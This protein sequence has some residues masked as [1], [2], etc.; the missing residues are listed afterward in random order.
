MTNLTKGLPNPWDAAGTKYLPGQKAKGKVVN[1]TAWGAFIELEP[2][3]EGLLHVTELSWGRSHVKPAEVL[4]L[5]QDIEVVVLSFNREEQR[6][7][8]SL[9]QLEANPWNKASEKYPPGTRVKCKVRNITSFGAFVEFEDGIDGMVH[10]LDISWTRSISQPGEVLVKGDEVEV[11]VRKVDVANRRFAL[12]IK[13]LTEDPW[14]PIDH[15]FKLGDVVTGKVNR[16][17]SHDLYLDLGHGVHGLLLS[18]QII[19]EP[20]HQLKHVFSVGQEVTDR[21][22]SIDKA[23]RRVELSMKAAKTAA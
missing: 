5:D 1:L 11:I 4:K 17:A 7:S 20:V 16:V 21:I 23:D 3:I 2:G 6:I 8:L 10:V 22:I 14:E 12:S 9:R 13:H 18:T 15:F 19:D